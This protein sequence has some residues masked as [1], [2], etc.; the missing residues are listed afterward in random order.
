LLNELSLY[1]LDLV[2]NSIEA[3]ATFVK[4]EIVENLENDIFSISIE[5]NGRG[6]PKELLKEVTDPFYTTRKTRKVGLGLALASQLA[7]DCNGKLFID[8]S[9]NGTRVKIELQHSHIDRPPLGNIIDTLLLLVC[10]APDVDFVYVHRVDRRE[11]VFDTRRLK[12]VLGEDIPLNLPSVVEFIKE[13]L[14]KGL[15]NLFGGANIND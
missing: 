9:E 6:I 14:S 12:S 1:I 11:F 3:G 8:S 4:I 15:S 2:Q 10:G 5:D 13:E 7:K